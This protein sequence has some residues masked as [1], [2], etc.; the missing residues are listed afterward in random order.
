MP[1]ATGDEAPVS[2]DED[3]APAVTA[4]VGDET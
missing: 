4:A 1:A 3:V 2:V